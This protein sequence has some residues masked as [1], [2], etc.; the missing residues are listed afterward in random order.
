MI[1]GFYFSKNKMVILK[2]KEIFICNFS[3]NKRERR[4]KRFGSLSNKDKEAL[5]NE[6]LD[7]CSERSALFRVLSINVRHIGGISSLIILL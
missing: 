3:K 1:D 2:K 7:L 6:V 4:I 5:S